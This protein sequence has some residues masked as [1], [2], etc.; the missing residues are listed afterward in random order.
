M[1]ERR[2]MILEPIFHQPGN[3]PAAR[4]LTG[5]ARKDGNSI[6]QHPL[7]ALPCLYNIRSAGKRDAAAWFRGI[8]GTLRMQARPEHGASACAPVWIWIFFSWE[9]P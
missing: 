4:R 6:K 9:R 3:S 2:G 7:A 1:R 8:A 5:F